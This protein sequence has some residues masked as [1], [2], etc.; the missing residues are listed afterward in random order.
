[1]A[2]TEHKLDSIPAL[3]GRIRQHV[4]RLC[5]GADRH[6]GNQ[7]NRDATDYVT[8][9]M[10]TLGLAVET[11]PFQ[12]PDWRFSAS[13]LD[14]GGRS[15]AIHPG[16][17]SQRVNGTGRLAAAS[18]ALELRDLDARG[19]V[20]LL[21]GEIAR[22]QLTPR[23]YPWYTDDAHTAII[24]TLERLAPVAV[25]SATGKNPAMTAGMS[26]F[27]LIEDPGFAVPTAYLPAVD[28]P[29]LLEHLGEVAAIDIASGTVPSPGM[30]PVGRLQGTGASRVVV[31]AH[32]DTKPETP[33]AL[34]NA[35]GVAVLLA[36]AELLAG[37]RRS[38]TVEFVP[39]NGE[40]HASSPGEVAYLEAHPDLSDVVLMINLDGVGLRNAPTAWSGYGL[41]A[42]QQD[43]VKMIAASGSTVIAGPPWPASDHMVFAT[44]GTPSL[45]LTT[46]DFERFSGTIAHTLADTPGE[47]DFELLYDTACFVAAVIEGVSRQ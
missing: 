33:G 13:T 25:V 4:L 38:V 27:P 18:S 26:P 2:A 47:V 43:L 14:I 29:V 1:M 17:F 44:R 34:D 15:F 5:E 32:I 24:D 9:V 36:V 22:I 45:A 3:A 23:G 37:I 42:V 11:L 21:H 28:S 6:P 16:P 10:R 19:A 30:Q 8:G 31:G 12:V 39:F 35:G 7:H 20:L 40:D 41:T 46:A